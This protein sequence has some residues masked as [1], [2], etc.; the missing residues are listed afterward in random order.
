MNA[1]AAREIVRVYQTAARS[2]RPSRLVMHAFCPCTL[3][4]TAVYTGPDV[5]GAVK[6]VE[7]LGT[8]EPCKRSQIPAEPAA[9]QAGTIDAAELTRAMVTEPADEAG[10]AQWVHLTV[11]NMDNAGSRR[12]DGIVSMIESLGGYCFSFGVKNGTGSGI[13]AFEIRALVPQIIAQ[14]LPM[15]AQQALSEA[16][17]FSRTMTKAARARLRDA[18]ADPKQ[19][20]LADASAR[21]DLVSAGIA[22]YVRRIDAVMVTGAGQA[23]IAA[24]VADLDKR[25]EAVKSASRVHRAANRLAR[26]A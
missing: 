9:P 23:W 6:A 2:G 15:L 3:P 1:T 4:G 17:E 25:A 24:N 22:E 7:V 13:Y 8:P 16:D 19:I 14:A 5:P 21:R 12:R 26:Q 10:R 11:S 18:G 20:A